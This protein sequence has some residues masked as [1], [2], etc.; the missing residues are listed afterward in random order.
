VLGHLLHH[1]KN[2]DVHGIFD[3]ALIEATNYVLDHSELLEQ[4]SA[5]IKNFMTEDILLAVDPQVRESF[6]GGVQNLS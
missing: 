3:D 1:V 4:F 2:S 5:S 6:L